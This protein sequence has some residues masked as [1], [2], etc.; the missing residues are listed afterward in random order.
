MTLHFGNLTQIIMY[1]LG[2][3]VHSMRASSIGCTGSRVTVGTP[4]TPWRACLQNRW[5]QDLVLCND[6]F[7]QPSEIWSHRIFY[8]NSGNV[9]TKITLMWLGKSW[10]LYHIGFPTSYLTIKSE[11]M[12]SRITVPSVFKQSKLS[13]P[14]TAT[15]VEYLLDFCKKAAGT[16]E[17]LQ[18]LWW[19]KVRSKLKLSLSLNAVSF[20]WP[21]YFTFGSCLLLDFISRLSK[22][23]TTKA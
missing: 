6:T 12:W 9:D 7:W 14:L 22:H 1:Y 3:K 20:M 11:V 18:K 15:S 13:L 19:S 21:V 4:Y 5:C 23:C 2:K 17:D 8:E 16:N 10:E